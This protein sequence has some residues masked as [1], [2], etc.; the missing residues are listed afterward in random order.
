MRS[1]SRLTVLVATIAGSISSPAPAFA[2]FLLPHQTRRS[3][4]HPSMMTSLRASSAPD[5]VAVA[6]VT[7]ALSAGLY[8][9]TPLIY[10]SSLT[11]LCGGNNPVY[12]KLDC[13]QPSGSFKDR[14]MGHLCA[15]L[16]KRGVRRL[17]SSS[18]GNAGLAAS[19]V[20]RKMGMD[21][22]VIVPETTKSIV[23]ARLRDLG[24]EVTVHGKN[25]NEA[26]ILAREIVSQSGGDS[27]YYVSPYDDPLLWTG[28]STAMEEILEDLRARGK[29]LGCIVASVGGGG[30]L[31]GIFEGLAQDGSPDAS[32]AAV[33]ACETNGAAGFDA[34]RRA[35]RPVTLAGITSVAT[36]LGAL[37]V[38][39]S[40]LERA[41]AHEAGGGRV[42]QSVCTDAEAIGACVGIAADHR[43][44]VEPAC[45]AALAAVYSDRLR[46]GT[47]AGL[48]E[49]TALVVEV[50]GG[51]GVDLSLLEGWR[52][53]FLE[54]QL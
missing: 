30:L 22:S 53:E 31:C 26:D 15:T 52:R 42:A 28:H 10:S 48:E 19:T 39:E 41:S 18:G 27:Q 23:L 6:G 32:A 44:L 21:I 50:C 34:A 36:S 37:E 43:L 14:G 47:L 9:R 3:P 49:G 1:A 12:L 45:G 24:A 20:G 25:W 8:E 38:T 51:S 4:H 5:A 2:L 54:G 11:E 35:G 29:K 13:L 46:E 33:I 40:A 16:A 17:V 7:D